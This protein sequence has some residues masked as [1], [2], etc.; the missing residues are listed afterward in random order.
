VIR[1]HKLLHAAPLLALGLLASC[2]HSDFPDYA[3]GYREFAYVTNSAANTVS[4]LDLVNLRPDRTLQVGD[5]PGAM[6]AN[7]KRDEVYVVNSQPGQSA[8]S[9]SVI[10]TTKNTVVATIPVKRMPSYISVDQ[11]GH[12]AYVADTGSNAVSVVDL[13]ARRVITTVRATDKPAEAVISADGRALV[14]TSRTNGTT[15]IYAADPLGTLNLR[16][17]FKG[18]AGA[19]GAVILPDSSKTYVACSGGHQLMVIALAAEAGSFA[20][21]QGQSTS[22]DE[23]VALLDVGKNPASLTLKPDGGEVFVSNEGSNSVSEVSTQT[24]EVGSTYPIGNKPAHGVVNA[25]NSELWISNSG[26][27]SIS[28][29]SI[30]DGRLVSSLHTD[31]GPDALAFSEDQHLLL[32]ADSRAGNVALVR[33]ASRLGPAL[34]TM[35]PVGNGPSAI[36]V[37]AMQPKA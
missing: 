24:N 14:V 17:T 13:D 33:T 5:T 23:V 2:R 16:A 26:A 7:P 11:T 12:L 34:F 36:V 18:C 28:L 1:P 31:D 25:D 9:V 10:D 19:T 15:S 27:D 8:G 4:V 35:L 29:Y 22:A 20:A 21:R 30:L 37:K 3:A 32:A 6:A